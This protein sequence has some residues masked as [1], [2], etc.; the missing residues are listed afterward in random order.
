MSTN[1]D[2]NELE[3]AADQRAGPDVP[4]AVETT[5]TYQT[6]DGTVFYDAEN[7]IAWIQTDEPLRLADVA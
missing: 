3:R 7:P 2:A 1:A 6:D 5:E 4:A